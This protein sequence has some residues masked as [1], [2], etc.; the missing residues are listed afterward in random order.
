ML[1]RK[2][3]QLFW[4]SLLE[5]VAQA[6]IVVYLCIWEIAMAAKA[7]AERVHVQMANALRSWMHSQKTT[8]LNASLKGLVQYTSF[9]QRP[10]LPVMVEFKDLAK[11]LLPE[12][13]NGCLGQA[14]FHTAIIELQKLCPGCLTGTKQQLQFYRSSV[15]CCCRVLVGVYR[16][17]KWKTPADVREKMLATLPVPTRREVEHG[18]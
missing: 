7:E 17:L 4:A 6:P 11:K 5:L 13:P 3:M 1:H 8:D 14:V 10:K 9:K 18:G 16:K 2:A 12:A 15:N